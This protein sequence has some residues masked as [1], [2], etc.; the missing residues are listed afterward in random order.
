[1]KEGWSNWQDLFKNFSYLRFTSNESSGNGFDVNQNIWCK[2]NI[3]H[4]SYRF[5]KSFLIF[6]QRFVCSE[7]YRYCRGKQRYLVF[8]R[9]RKFFSIIFLFTELFFAF[10]QRSCFWKKV[11]IYRVGCFINLIILAWCEIVCNYFSIS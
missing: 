1:M 5:H 3:L 10:L 6:W 11:T 4:K 9:F 8:I 2:E 7:Y